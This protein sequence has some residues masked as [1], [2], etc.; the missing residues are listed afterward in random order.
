MGHGIDHKPGAAQRRLKRQGHN[1]AR[2]N[3]GAHQHDGLARCRE[4]LGAIR[5]KCRAAYGD[6]TRGAYA[7]SGRRRVRG[8]ARDVFALSFEY[9]MLWHGPLAAMR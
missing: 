3:V 2:V 7:A 4:A 8:K 1:V 9:E 5:V 6:A